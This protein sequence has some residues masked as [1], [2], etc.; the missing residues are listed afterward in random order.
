MNWYE[1]TSQM[2]KLWSQTQ[3]EMLSNW[4]KA[5]SAATNSAATGS[6]TTMN[7]FWR[8]TILQSIRQMNEQMDPTAKDVAQKLFTSQITTMQLIETAM[9]MWQAILP[10][11]QAGEEWQTTFDKQMQLTRNQILQFATSGLKSMGNVQQLWDKYLSELNSFSAPWFKSI[12][13]SSKYYER[14]LQGD[15]TALIEM[16]S[17]YNDAFR[18]SFGNLLQMPGLGYTREIDAKVR[19]SFASWVEMQQASYEYQLVVVEAWLEAFERLI[20]ELAQLAEQGET[21]DSVRD[22]LN[23]WSA[24]AD[25]TF[26][27]TFH[28]EQYVTLQGKYI[29]TVMEYRNEQRQMNTMLMEFYDIPT[30]EEIDETHRRIYELRKE[31]RL[32]KR[33]IAELKAENKPSTA[34][35]SSPSKT[36]TKKK[37]QGD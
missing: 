29:N 3:Q 24:L 20:Q 17:L 23:R 16:T 18:D 6:F 30:R 26:K 1:H 36:R 21:L 5:S 35:K 34:K 32:L 37:E 27:K 12:Q 14:L 13:E 19:R 33:E 11:I 2:M 25:E 9:Q 15:G 8:T 28:S 22:F 31:L 7:D 4:A 10:K